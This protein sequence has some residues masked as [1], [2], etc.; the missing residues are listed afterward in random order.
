MGSIELRLRKLETCSR[1]VAVAIRFGNTNRKICE[2]PHC[3]KLKYRCAAISLARFWRDQGR[4][5]QARELLAQVYGW[6]RK[7]LTRAI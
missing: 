5:Q 6:L 7:G 4:V 3:K 2:Y 1:R